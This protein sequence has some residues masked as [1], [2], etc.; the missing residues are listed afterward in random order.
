MVDRLVKLI[1]RAGDTRFLH[2]ELQAQKEEGFERRVHVY[3]SRAGDHVGQD[4]VSVAVLLD[5][6]PGWRPTEYVFECWGCRKAFTP[7]RRRRHRDA[8]NSR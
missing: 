8:R 1:T 2:V 6:D 3:N 5:G 4:V 7:L